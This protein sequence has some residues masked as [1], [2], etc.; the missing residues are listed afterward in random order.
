MARPLYCSVDPDLYYPQEA[1]PTW[2]LGYMGTY[3]LDRQGLST[4]C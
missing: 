3:S 4:V 2:S 1:E